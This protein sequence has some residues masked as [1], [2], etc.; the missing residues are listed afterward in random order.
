[1]N[2]QI[3]FFMEY[4]LELIRVLVVCA[5]IMY[6]MTQGTSCLWYDYVYNDTGY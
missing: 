5:M 4:S 6:I 1:M 2:T 3:I